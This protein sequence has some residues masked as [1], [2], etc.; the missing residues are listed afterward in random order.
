MVKLN[1]SSTLNQ[2]SQRIFPNR[3]LHTSVRR[4]C[5]T[6]KLMNNLIAKNNFKKACK[7]LFLIVASTK[8]MKILN[9]VLFFI[10]KIRIHKLLKRNCYYE[11]QN[12]GKINAIKYLCHLPLQSRF[13]S[14]DFLFIKCVGQFH[15]LTSKLK[16]RFQS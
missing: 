7:T 12:F 2:Q 3:N 11:R 8:S 14:V 15:R 13:F 5:T 6:T 16:G 1:N 9:L 4:L 10:F